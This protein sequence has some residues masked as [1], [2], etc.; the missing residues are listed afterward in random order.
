MKKY[1]IIYYPKQ[2]ALNKKLKEFDNDVAMNE[3]IKQKVNS[4]FICDQYTYDSSYQ[5]E[6]KILQTKE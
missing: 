4:G 6:T 5:L 1:V 3:F 2:S